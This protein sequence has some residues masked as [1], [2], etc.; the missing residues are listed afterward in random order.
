MLHHA[1]A[2][3]SRWQAAY[4]EMRAAIEESGRDARWEFSKTALFSS[5]NYMAEVQSQHDSRFGGG[6][7]YIVWASLR[8]SLP[9]HAQENETIECCA[10]GILQRCTVQKAA[11]SSSTKL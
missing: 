8:R 4:L 2:A 5:S 11:S 1:G 6:H 9:R 3:L 7:G 10:F